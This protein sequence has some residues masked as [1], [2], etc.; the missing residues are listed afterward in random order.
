MYTPVRIIVVAIERHHCPDTLYLTKLIRRECLKNAKDLK[1]DSG[2]GFKS[3]VPILYREVK[4]RDS[5][6]PANTVK[7][8]RLD[9]RTR[10]QQVLR[11]IYGCQTA[12]YNHS[13]SEF[14]I[15]NAI[16]STWGFGNG[17]YDILLGILQRMGSY[18]LSLSHYPSSGVQNSQPHATDAIPSSFDGNCDQSTCKL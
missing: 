9:M 17:R 4:I 15:T 18:P 2:R 3:V 8:P 13:G 7:T 6:L 10:L 12:I 11:G 16:V 1:E 5:T 14:G